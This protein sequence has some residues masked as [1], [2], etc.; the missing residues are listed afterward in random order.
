MSERWCQEDDC[1]LPIPRWARADARYCCNA[2]RQK[3]YRQHKK[4]VA[5]MVLEHGSVEAALSDAVTAMNSIIGN[6]KERGRGQHQQ[7]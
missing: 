3:A 1:G 7:A 6:T 4:R 2:C 5:V